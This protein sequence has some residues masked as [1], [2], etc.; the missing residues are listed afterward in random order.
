MTKDKPVITYCTIGNRASLAWF[1]L[2]H[3]LGYPDVAVYYG[4][5]VDWGKRPDT[6]IET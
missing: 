2:K 1:A 5:W 3:V 6:P 4:S